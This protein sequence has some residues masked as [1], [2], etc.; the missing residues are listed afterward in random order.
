MR[1]I[2]LAVVSDIHAGDE[3][4]AHTYVQ[5]EPPRAKRNR[6]PLSDLRHLIAEKDIRSDYLIAPGDIANKADAKGVA[7][8]W[9]QL[10]AIA[11]QLEARL[12]S[13]PGNHDVVTHDAAS[14]PRAMLK[15]LLPSFPTGDDTVDAAFWDK[16]WTAIENADHRILVIDSTKGFPEYPVGLSK[17]SAKWNEY[18]QHI[19]RGSITTDMEAQIDEYL[20]KLSGRKTNIA[21]IHHHPQEHQMRDFLQDEYGPMFQGSNIID[22]LT[23]YPLSGRW[24]L[25]H[26]HK[27]IPQLVNAVSSSSN[28][29]LILCS[30]SIGAQIW[31]PANTVA[32]N[33]F[34][35][36]SVSSDGIPGMGS[37][38]GTIDSYTWGFGDG[39]SISERQG[40]GLP[41]KSGF[42]CTVDSATLAGHIEE[43]MNEPRLEFMP[44]AQMLEKVPHLPYQLPGD[45]RSLED[46]LESRGFIFERD[47][48]DRLTQLS[49]RVSP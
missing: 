25:I 31:P 29:P 27:H 16:G 7:Y 41:A 33:Q 20:S 46:D 9:R 35:L 11:T 4:S 43:I 15:S 32:R 21:L 12:I 30:A 45:F 42:G 28:G 26:G 6:H 34:H 5:V 44:Y 8:A 17:K 39:W 22:C 24:I 18:K 10:N 23:R 38:S 3:Q 13:T 40:S 2:Q 49:R 37:I 1:T 36:L 47:R 14:D 48:Y 19:D